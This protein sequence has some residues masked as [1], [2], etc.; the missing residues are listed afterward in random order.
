MNHEF[1]ECNHEFH[2]L[3]TMNHE[4]QQPKVY[5]PGAGVG[6]TAGQRSKETQNSELRTQNS[7]LTTSGTLG[8]LGTSNKFNE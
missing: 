1:H 3:R 8:T 2:E 6:K 7:Q 4:T 5:L